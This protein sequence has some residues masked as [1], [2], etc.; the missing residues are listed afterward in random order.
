ME[1]THRERF[2]N[3]FKEFI[4]KD[5]PEIDKGSGHRR[6]YDNP[7]Q[8]TLKVI[9]YFT[10]KS[11]NSEPFTGVGLSLYLGFYNKKSFWKDYLT[12]QFFA[13]DFSALIGIAH[14]LIEN[15]NVESLYTKETFN[16]SRFIL[17]C[18]YSDYIQIE[19]RIVESNEISVSIGKKKNK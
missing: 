11:E 18:G 7:K 12:S 19:K 1:T 8:M 2:K 17:S 15:F 9:D 16:A 14:Q 6:K 4:E 3:L 10:E 13:E 5:Y